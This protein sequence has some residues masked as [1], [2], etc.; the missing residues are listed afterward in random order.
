MRATTKLDRKVA[1]LQHT[2]LI[3][4]FFTEQRHRATVD[5]IVVTHDLRFSQRVQTNLFIDQGLDLS[6][7]LSRQRFVMRKVEAQPVRCNQ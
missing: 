1:E 4:V 3:A 5:G 2:N 6:N 7:L